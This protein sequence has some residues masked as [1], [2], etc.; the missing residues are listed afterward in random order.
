[1]KKLLTL[2]VAVLFAFAANAQ[3]T[4]TS[5][6]NVPNPLR[7]HAAGFSIG[8][9]GYL[10][11]GETSSG[12]DLAD[13]YEYDPSNNTWTTKTNFPGT[14]RSYAVGFS[15]GTKGYICC[16]ISGSTFLKDLWE[17]DASNDT[18][19]QKAAFPGLGRS[20]PVAVVHKGEAYVGCG[21]TQ[22]GNATDFFKYNATSNT[23]T[24]VASFTGT[25]RHHPSGFSVGS[26][27]YVGTGHDLTNAYKKDFYVFGSGWTAI[28]DIPGQGRVAAVGLTLNNKGLLFWGGDDL[29]TAYSDYFSFDTLSQAWTSYTFSG[30]PLWGSVGFVVNGKGYVG[31]GLNSGSVKNNFYEITETTS[32]IVSQE[33]GTYSL[34]PNPMVSEAVLSL[35]KEHSNAEL[36]ICDLS[37]RELR[38]IRFSGREVGIKREGLES[39]MYLCQVIVSGKAVLTAKMLIAGN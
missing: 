11:T 20:H 30:V 6:A 27:M 25:A 10:G 37:G 28:T 14:A 31:S 1:M 23:W 18:W 7:H 12:A 26:K 13:W 29:G 38:N 5:K 17:Y 22:S 4:I 35:D 34:Y 3:Y 9:K 32:G 39:G 8:N 36:R 21:S 19:V 24:P 33:E 15:I 2:I 16:G